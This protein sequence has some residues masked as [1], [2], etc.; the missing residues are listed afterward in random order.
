M[1]KECL[2]LITIFLALANSRRMTALSV[3]PVSFGVKIKA[4]VREL[5]EVVYIQFISEDFLALV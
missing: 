3:L 4:S 2:D 5:N 1:F